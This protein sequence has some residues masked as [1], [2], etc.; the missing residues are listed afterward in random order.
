MAVHN[1]FGAL[2]L[3]KMYIYVAVTGQTVEPSGKYV[4]TS[5][6]STPTLPADLIDRKPPL[7]DFCLTRN[8]SVLKKFITAAV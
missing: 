6:P 7:G 2:K 1:S 5:L 8:P 4:C 3:E